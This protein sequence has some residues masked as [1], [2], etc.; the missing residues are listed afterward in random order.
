MN[1]DIESKAAIVK[2]SV[3]WTGVAVGGTTLSWAEIAAILASVY[4]LILIGE[5]L[6]KRIGRPLLERFNK[7][8]SDGE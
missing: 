6:W 2:V 1:A 8:D 4:S 7:G 3:L 5:W